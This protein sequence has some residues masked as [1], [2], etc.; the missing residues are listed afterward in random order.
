MTRSKYFPLVIIIT[1]LVPLILVSLGTSGLRQH[2]NFSRGLHK[3]LLY[4]S[5]TVG[6]F[7]GNIFRR[8]SD[9]LDK[10]D[11]AL[12]C[13][14]VWGQ[15]RQGTHHSKEIPRT[16]RDQRNRLDPVHSETKA[17]KKSAKEWDQVRG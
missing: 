5:W 11:P 3:H 9:V 14:S 8:T 2:K 4:W 1:F 10:C 17:K 7:V 6:L 12:H 13:S 16:S 15:L